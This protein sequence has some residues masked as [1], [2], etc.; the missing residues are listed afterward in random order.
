M[1]TYIGNNVRISFAHDDCYVFEFL[2]SG[3]SRGKVYLPWRP[4]LSHS[5][6][7]IQQQQLNDVLDGLRRIATSAGLDWPAEVGAR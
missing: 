3:H 6:T 7:V 2:Q 1:S 4:T 5:Q